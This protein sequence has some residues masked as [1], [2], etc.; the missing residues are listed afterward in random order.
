MK[1]KMET[2]ETAPSVLTTDSTWTRWNWGDKNQNSRRNQKA[3]NQPW[4]KWFRGLCWFWAPFTTEE[5]IPGYEQTKWAL[6]GT[7]DESLFTFL[8]HIYRQRERNRFL[9]GERDGGGALVLPQTQMRRDGGRALALERD[10][11]PCSRLTNQLILALTSSIPFL[12][13]PSSQFILDTWPL[14]G[15]HPALCVV[16]IHVFVVG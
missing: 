11:P 13:N 6:K 4:I 2:V 1:E 9:G 10:A 15:W 8:P 5:C 14:Y 12:S 16:Y 7:R 3:R